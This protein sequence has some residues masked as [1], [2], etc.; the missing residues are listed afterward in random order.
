MFFIKRNSDFK[1]LNGFIRFY[2]F[3]RRCHYDVLNLRRNCSDKE[4]K[5]AFIQLSKEYHPDKNKD[6]KAQE[7]FVQ[8]VEAYNILGKPG[9]RAQYD[10]ITEVSTGPNSYVYKT[11]VPYN[12]RKNAQYSYYY[13]FGSKAHS[14]KGNTN[15][16]YSNESAKK[17]P[18]YYIIFTCIGIT[19]LGAILQGYVIRNMY[20]G[21]RKQALQKSMELADELDKVRA[22]ATGNGN[23]MQTR[24]LL[25]K[26]VTASN[27]TV[28]TASLGHAL[29]T[30]KKNISETFVPE[31]GIADA[32]E[33]YSYECS[34]NNDLKL[35]SE[36][37]QKIME[38]LE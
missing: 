29:A 36:L 12:L 8:I 2:S 38:Y 27:A 10:S 4:I 28:A 34:I 17:M 19:L 23:E 11:H 5:N 21:Q 13:D 26:I 37:L 32:T 33:D 35:L 16:Y 9:T 1:S 7:R 31:Y 22:A 3:G 24:L 18:N 25:D 14:A 20:V 30:D 15:T 6:A